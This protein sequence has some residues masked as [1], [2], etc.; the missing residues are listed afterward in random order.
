MFG[1]DRPTNPDITER[2][3][4][5]YECPRTKIPDDRTKNVPL[6]TELLS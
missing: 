1:D 2:M 5:R 3:S 4:H 6:P